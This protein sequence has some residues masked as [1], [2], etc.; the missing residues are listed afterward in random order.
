MKKYILSLII[1]FVIIPVFVSAGFFDW[2]DWSKKEKTANN[3]NLGAATIVGVRQGGTG[4]GG[5]PSLGD[6]LVGTSD[7]KYAPQATSTLGISGGGGFATTS[8]DYWLTTKDTDDLT[9]GSTNLYWTE[10]RGADLFEKMTLGALADVSTSTLAI[11]H[12]TM[13]DGN[14]WQDS[15]TSSLGI[16]GGSNTQVNFNDGNTLAGDPNFTWDKTANRLT[17]DYATIT[18][19]SIS[20]NLSLGDGDESIPSLTF[21]TGFSNGIHLQAPGVIDVNVGNQFRIDIGGEAAIYDFQ[22]T[23]LLPLPDNSIALGGTSNNFSDLFLGD[24]SVINWNNSDII[25]THSSNVLTL[26]GGNLIVPSATSTGFYTTSFGINSEYFNDLTGTG[27]VNT[28]GVLTLQAGTLTNGKGCKYVL[29]T[30]FVCDQDYLTGN[31]TITL[32]GDVSGSG[33]TA[34]TTAIGNDKV[35]PNMV[36]SAGQT[37]EYCLTYEATGTTWEWQTC[38]S[39]GGVDY[40]AAIGDVSTTSPTVGYGSLLGWDANNSIW[41]DFATNT[42]GI[43]AAAG[44]SDTQLQYNN[45]GT[46]LGGTSALTYN[47]TLNFLGIGTTTPSTILSVYGT[48][49]L[50]GMGYPLEVWNKTDSTSNQVAHF[51]ANQR[52]TP[53]DN[54]QGYLSFYG[55]TDTSGQQEFGRIIWEM[56][57]V[58]NTTKD[59]TLRFYNMINNSLTDGMDLV[60][61]DLT[62]NGIITA[63][64]GGLQSSAITGGKVGEASTIS[65]NNIFAATKTVWSSSNSF[66]LLSATTNGF[67]YAANPNVTLSASRAYSTMIIGNLGTTNVTEATSGNHPLIS[68]LAIKPTSITAGAATVSDTASLYIEG[69]ATTTVVSG[70]NYALWVDNINP[71]AGSLSRF[72]GQTE[73]G[74]SSPSGM[75]TLWGQGTGTDP[76]L[77]IANSASTTLFTLLDNGTFTYGTPSIIDAGGATSLEIP[78]GASPS[79][80]AIGQ[81]ALDTT[82]NQILFATSTTANSEAVIRTVE[83]IFA[84]DI[85][86]TSPQFAEGSVLGLPLEEAYSVKEIKCYVT[87][88]TSKAI[89]LF[90]TSLTCDTDGASSTSILTPASA[91]DAINNITMG[92]TV[93]AVDRVKITIL[94]TWTRQ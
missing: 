45:G 88:G 28:D 31:Q 91:E 94:G 46:A 2:F 21:G 17:F 23:Q 54:D 5:V 39:G 53:A 76:L 78:N 9:E 25:L 32:S 69:G 41:T 11:G 52:V 63:S 36:H 6:I 42:L 27:L 4:T 50:A 79:M 40:L 18:S 38:G 80:T 47:D 3:E 75:V 30:G 48:T 19:A 61:K 93:G 65:S 16:Y 15:A 7:G 24:G 73:F 49:T 55:Q 57:D 14:N 43:T 51:L 82:A 74:T 60:G 22:S 10:A 44:G 34:I 1:G 84:F 64:N 77:N 87:S 89:T 59:S 66:S 83:K 62:V 92:A 58:T 71:I 85:A 29:G 81:I 12:I 68:Q 86:S 35:I 67:V 37:D 13:W 56:D 70:K 8:A 20:D 33:A 26:T 72:D 90:G